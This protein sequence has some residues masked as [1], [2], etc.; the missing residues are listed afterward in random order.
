MH[1]TVALVRCTAPD[2]SQ[3]WSLQENPEWDTWVEE[4]FKAFDVDGSGSIG[5]QELQDVLCRDGVCHMPDVVSSALREAD[6]DGD[7]KITLD[8]FVRLVQ[9]NKADRLS[10]FGDRRRRQ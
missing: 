3:R 9:L 5:V 4:G 7:Q 6:Q 10:N 8:D 2:A 1:V